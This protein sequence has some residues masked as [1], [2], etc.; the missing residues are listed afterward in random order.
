MDLLIK[1][2]INIAMIKDQLSFL[3]LS[4]K[5]ENYLELSQIFLGNLKEEVFIKIDTH[6]YF[7]LDLMDLY[8]SLAM[9][10]IKNKM[11]LY[12]VMIEWLILRVLF[13]FMKIVMMLLIKEMIKIGV[14]CIKDLTT[15]TME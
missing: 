13:A 7:L 4:K 1:A 6:F 11:K 8:Q 3:F 15:K 2:F 12:I 5:L 14:I 10:R 9:L